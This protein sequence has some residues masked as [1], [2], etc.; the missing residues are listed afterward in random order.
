MG[1]RKFTVK[2]MV[3]EDEETGEVRVLET[4]R[5]FAEIEEAI[6]KDL[7]FA[8]KLAKSQDPDDKMRAKIDKALAERRLFDLEDRKKARDAW[9]KH[10]KPMEFTLLKPTYLEFTEAESAATDQNLDSGVATVSHAK[11]MQNLM[12]VSIEGMDRKQVGE[13]DPAIVNYLWGRLH[14]SLYPDPNRLPFSPSPSKTGSPAGKETR[15][16]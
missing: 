13:L 4:D 3:C 6:Q 2:C 7:R 9:L 5:D 14:R 10:A 16:D 15:P 11:L 12:P 8:T 1:I